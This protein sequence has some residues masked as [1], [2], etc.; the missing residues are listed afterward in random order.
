MQTRLW[1][2]TGYM[3]I[4]L[5]MSKAYNRAKWSFLEA[6]MYK[7]GFAN[8]WIKLIMTC[9]KTV[10]IWLWLMEM[11]WGKLFLQEEL[12]KEILFLFIY[13][14]FVLKLLAL[15]YKMLN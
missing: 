12:D 8:A 14:L 13:L 9:V 15:F 6:V 10:I 7:L 11:W 1:S 4:E 2:K 5:D 3:S